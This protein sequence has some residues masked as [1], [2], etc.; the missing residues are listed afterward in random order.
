MITDMKLEIII[1]DLIQKKPSKTETDMVV[2]LL[3]Q[4]HKHHFDKFYR[5]YLCL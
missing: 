2:S 5:Y 1:I 3:L 4:F